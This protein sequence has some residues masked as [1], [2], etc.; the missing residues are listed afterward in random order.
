MTTWLKP[1]DPNAAQPR[2]ELAISDEE[3][4]S[5]PNTGQ[6]SPDQPPAPPPEAKAPTPDVPPPPP[7]PAPVVP[8]GPPGLLI[9]SRR[10]NAR[11]RLMAHPVIWPAVG[12]VAS[13]L[14][15][16]AIAVWLSGSMLESDVKPLA[17]ERA[18]LLQTPAAQRDAA[19][20]DRIEGQI[21]AA[22][23]TVAWK[24][25]GLWSLVFAAG[26]FTWSRVF[27]D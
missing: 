13:L 25:G 16:L 24:T 3:I 18:I 7:A 15:G 26:L 4:Y 19:R 27:R 6:K 9:A 5:T 20:I 14:A 2:I 10:K 21:T 12:A 11:E 17:T 1:E 23:S 8:A 22:R